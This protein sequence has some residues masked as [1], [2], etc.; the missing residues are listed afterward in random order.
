MYF[1]KF[2]CR[3]NERAYPFESRTWR[4]IP[5]RTN[6]VI[7]FLCLDLMLMSLH[8]LVFPSL[9]VHCNLCSF[10]AIRYKSR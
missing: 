9:M 2:F 3:V 5:S 8:F 1:A 10:N 6:S 7:K 4:R